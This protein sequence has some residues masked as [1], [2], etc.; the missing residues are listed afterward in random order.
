MSN[1]SNTT[2]DGLRDI[3][4]ISR[5]NREVKLLLE[6]E[7]PL[8][9]VEGEL[10]N[11]ARP[12]SGHLYFSLKDSNA[13]VSCAMFRNRSRN[14]DFKAED[15]VAVLARVRVSLYEPRGNYQLIVEHMEEAGA[16]ALQREFELLK[17]RLNKEGLFNEAHKQPIPTLPK[18]IGV[19]TSESGAAIRDVISVL[20]RRFPSIPVIIYPVPVQGDGA[21]EKIADMVK[22]ADKRGECDVLIVTRGGGS[23]EDLWAFNEEVLARTIYHCNTPVVSA[24]GHEI[25]FTISDF[26]ADKRA[27]TP[28]AAA[29]MVSPDRSEW[30]QALQVQ[31]N[32]LC[33]AMQSIQLRRQQQLDFLEKRLQHPGKRLEIIGKR[34]QDLQTRLSNAQTVSLKQHRA[35][36]NEVTAQLHQHTP[37]HRLNRLQ[38]QSASLAS[39]LGS[40]IKVL[41]KA[42]QQQF[43]SISH[44]LEAVSPLATLNR[45]YAIVRH[46]KDRH[47]IRRC[48]DVSSGQQIEAALSDGALL[49][50][51]EQIREND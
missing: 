3:F 41:V 37:M 26:V 4:S 34:V 38:A 24:I 14:L 39:R 32:R 29:E 9:W 35:H 1:T 12:S 6:N 45:G 13:Q 50:R 10:S 43:L 49:C 19:I 17:Q 30:Q 15:G 18:Q 21:G 46:P 51:V 20:R 36:L 28:S 31:Y 48:R 2:P 47:I 8:I 22:L 16:G 44:T 23:L 7:F 5:L 11:I 25:D 40:A 33:N 27:A 42:R